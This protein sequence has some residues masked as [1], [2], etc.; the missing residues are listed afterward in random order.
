MKLNDAKAGYSGEI[1]AI[2]GDTRFLSRIT[3]IGLTIG[4]TIEIMKNDK[5]SRYCYLAEIL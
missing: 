3:S 5:N 1:T 4:C 2:D